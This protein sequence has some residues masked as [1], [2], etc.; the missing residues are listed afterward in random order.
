MARTPR[1]TPP[2]HIRKLRAEMELKDLSLRAVSDRSG[3]NYGTAS[4][5]LS[6]R[7]VHPEELKRLSQAIRTAPVPTS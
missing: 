5:V 6:G 7:R 1:F 2:L 3:V 4:S